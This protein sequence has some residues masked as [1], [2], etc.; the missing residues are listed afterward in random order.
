MS[1]PIDKLEFWKKRIDEAPKEHYSV[2]IIDEFRWKRILDSHI[3]RF[4]EI[5]PKGSKVLDAGCG[6]GRMSEY[7]DNYT[8]VDF[9]PDFINKA[10]SK[11]PDKNFIVGN[12]KELPFRDKE[13]DWAFCV[14]IKA[15]VENNLGKDEWAKMQKELL[16]VSKKVL[17]LEY[18]DYN[19]FEI[20]DERI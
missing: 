9:S 20:L 14:S 18:E 17:I 4:E 16:R 3:K 1:K 11:Y 12:L 6:Y 19:F 10:K 5:I 2:Y 13:F 15:M 8:G 7:F